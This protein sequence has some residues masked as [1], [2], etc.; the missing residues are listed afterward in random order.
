MLANAQAAAAEIDQVI[1]PI[2]SKVFL[3]LQYFIQQ[4]AKP[5]DHAIH[6][7]DPYIGP[8]QFDGSVPSLQAWLEEMMAEGHQASPN[9]VT[10][11]SYLST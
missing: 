10:A 5:A 7:T 3:I 1:T 2:N 9:V 6:P 4:L 11:L 8:F